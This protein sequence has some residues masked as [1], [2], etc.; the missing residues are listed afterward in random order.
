MDALR[1]GSDAE[2]PLN[3]RRALIFNGAFVLVATSFVALLQGKQ[4][5]KHMD[6]IK[7]QESTQTRRT[8]EE[9]PL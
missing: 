3:M 2:P 7:L 6:E 8:D 4:V 5:R 9:A 1:A